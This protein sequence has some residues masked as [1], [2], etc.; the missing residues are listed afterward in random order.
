MIAAVGVSGALF[1]LLL[2]PGAGIFGDSG[3]AV[4]VDG[5]SSLI[6]RGQGKGLWL[7]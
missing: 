5:S 2:S 3:L 1:E 7:D 6:G 4:S